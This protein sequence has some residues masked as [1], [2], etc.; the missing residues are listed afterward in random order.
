[1]GR[2][3]NGCSS[4]SGMALDQLNVFV[5]HWANNGT[6]DRYLSSYVIVSLFSVNDCP[7]LAERTQSTSIFFQLVVTGLANFVGEG[8]HEIF[9][10]TVFHHEWVG[11]LDLANFVGMSLTLRVTATGVFF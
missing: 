11:D 5:I 1:M 8:E 2:A 10:C 3:R 9:G 4:I 6:F 7:Q